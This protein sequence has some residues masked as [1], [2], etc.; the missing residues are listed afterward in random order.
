[1]FRYSISYWERVVEISDII[2]FLCFSLQ[3]FWQ[4][5]PIFLIVLPDLLLGEDVTS[6]I[7]IPHAF[8]HTDCFLF[9]HTNQFR[10]EESIPWYLPKQR[11]K[12]NFLSRD[13][14]SNKDNKAW[15]YWSHHLEPENK[16]ISEESTKVRCQ[17]TSWS[18]S[19]DPATAECTGH[20]NNV[21]Q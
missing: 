17:E 15:N 11:G 7:S 16:A 4:Q 3:F 21:S 19:V 20:L 12:R 18:S 2:V 10:K 9:G 5:S 8:A 6:P 14:A 1:M 13:V